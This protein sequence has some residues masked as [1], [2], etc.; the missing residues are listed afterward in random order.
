MSR[1]IRGALL[2]LAAVGAVFAAQPAAATA[3]VWTRADA[4]GGQE[5]QRSW[6]DPSLAGSPYLSARSFAANDGASGQVY[7]GNFPDCALPAICAYAVDPPS[8]TARADRKSKR[9]NS[10]H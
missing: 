4:E 9:L 2:G 3:L 6:D 10:S 5:I 7:E 1:T 8:S